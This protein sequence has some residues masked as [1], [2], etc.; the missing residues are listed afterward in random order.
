MAWGTPLTAVSNAALTAAQWN[1]SV[2][3]NMLETAPAKAANAAGYFVTSTTNSIAERQIGYAFVGA[4]PE[5]ET[6]TSFTDLA[7]VGPSVTVTTGPRTIMAVSAL[8]SNNTVNASSSMGIDISG[9][10]TLAATDS[11]ALRPTSSTANASCEA[12]Y[13]T[14]LTVGAG[15]NTYTGKYKVST[16]T[17]SWSNRRITVMPF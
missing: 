8:I 16:G 6:S 17:G 12:S 13:L 4:S 10:Y 1:A 9:S 2:R 14:G 5:T 11:L 3:D 15:S 7:T